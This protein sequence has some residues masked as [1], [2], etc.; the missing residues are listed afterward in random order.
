MRPS[1]LALLA[2]LLVVAAPTRADAP[3]K[4]MSPVRVDA[5]LGDGVV[6]STDQL[7]L[8]FR[9]RAQFRAEGVTEG[10]DGLLGVMVRRLRAVSAAEMFEGTLLLNVQLSF[11][12]RDIEPDNPSVLRDA[13]LTWKPHREFNLK[14][15]QMKVVFDRQRMNSSS[16]LLLP[17]RS[18]AQT[19]LTLDRD[20]GVQVGSDDALGIDLIQ[21]QLAIYG[22]DGRGR[23]AQDVGLLYVARL[24]IT[25]FGSFDDLDETGV[26]RDEKLRV[27]IAFAGAFNDDSPRPKSTTGIYDDSI[28]TDF[29]HATADTLVKVSG[30]TLAA[31]GQLRIA[32]AVSG[33]QEA[34]SAVGG[35]VQLGIPA[36]DHIELAG[37]IG[38]LAPFVAPVRNPVGFV[39]QTEIRPGVNV[40]FHGHEAKLQGAVGLVLN[41]DGTRKVDGQLQMQ[42]WF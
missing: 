36:T 23:L 25:P 29:L 32:T 1:H 9:T 8:T 27:A 2:V 37:R 11:A 38:R 15:G 16:S 24:Q 35:F 3:V 6:V 14:V 5:Q 30:I 40:Y 33:A 21:Y 42:L 22:G 12:P 39:G 17:D 26:E 20:V 13:Y 19:E 10:E 4:S 28:R 7:K 18:L 41:D 34:S 31:Q